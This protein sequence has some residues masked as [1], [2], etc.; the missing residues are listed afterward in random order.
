MP[1]FFV[2]LQV[3]ILRRIAPP[4]P[5]PLQTV[6]DGKS[7]IQALLGPAIL[8]EIV[9]KVVVDFGSGHGLEAIEIAK[10]GATHVIGVEI[11]EELLVKA[12]DNAA[13]CCHWILLSISRIRRRFCG[14][15]TACSPSTE[16][17]SLAGGRHGFILT[18][19]T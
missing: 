15:C 4:V 5:K 11:E 14:S 6:Y 16:R 10:C 13:W 19:C 2:R 12:R 17:R 7:K 8:E 9:D 3:E 1:N 18:G